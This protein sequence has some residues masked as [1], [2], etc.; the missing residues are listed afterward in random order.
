MLQKR[1][2][3]KWGSCGMMSYVYAESA[4]EAICKLVTEI[5]AINRN[6]V[7]ICIKSVECKE[8]S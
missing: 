2:C 8:E 6:P 4:L 5:T 3:I 1:Y 7:E